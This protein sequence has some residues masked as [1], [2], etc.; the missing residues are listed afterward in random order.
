MDVRTSEVSSYCVSYWLSPHSYDEIISMEH[1][2]GRWF[3]RSY[4]VGNFDIVILNFDRSMLFN[5]VD[6]TTGDI[7]YGKG[8]MNTLFLILEYPFFPPRLSKTLVVALCEEKSVTLK[9]SWNCRNKNNV[10]MHL[11]IEFW[12]VMLSEHLTPSGRSNIIGEYY[13]YI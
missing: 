13:V 3:L 12:T 11:E 1:R 9:G 10:F 5:F 6:K 8:S 4:F 2:E 7:V